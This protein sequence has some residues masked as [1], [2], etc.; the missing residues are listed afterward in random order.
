MSSCLFFHQ[1]L[2]RYQ[3]F[4]VDIEVCVNQIKDL[5]LSVVTPTADSNEEKSSINSN[6]SNYDIVIVDVH[7]TESS[8]IVLE[9]IDKCTKRQVEVKPWRKKIAVR[10][11]K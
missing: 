2:P 1:E 11:I 9:K 10:P 5:A 8:P 6:N 4:S 7:R 3:S